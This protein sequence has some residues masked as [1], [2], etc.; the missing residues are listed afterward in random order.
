MSQASG[1]GGQEHGRSRARHAVEPIEVYRRLDE[2]IARLSADRR[3]PRPPRVSSEEARA[4]RQAAMFRAAAPGATD[5]DPVYR[6]RLVAAIQRLMRSRF[7]IW[8]PPAWLF[9]RRVRRRPA[10]PQ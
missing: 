3:P 6:A 8:W 9:S 4:F 2:H 5:P 7:R 1:Q 10:S